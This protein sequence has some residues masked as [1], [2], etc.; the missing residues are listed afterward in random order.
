MRRVLLA[1]AAVAIVVVGAVS[2]GFY[3]TYNELQAGAAERARAIKGAFRA[4]RRLDHIEAQLALAVSA[5][6]SA[7]ATQKAIAAELAEVRLHVRVLSA[8]CAA[9]PATESQDDSE[10]AV[11]GARGKC[12]CESRA[13][14]VEARVD[15]I[16]S[17]M[18]SLEYDL[19]SAKRDLT[20]LEAKSHD[21]T[22]S[23]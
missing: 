18:T 15:G 4:G 13:S 6:Q 10:G 23:E 12:G 14:S 3:F 8:T 5:Q 16:E 2:A 7:A 1:A 22:A 21:H 9:T 11:P 20:G 17:R 19:D